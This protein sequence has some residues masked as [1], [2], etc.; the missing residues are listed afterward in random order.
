MVNLVID[1]KIVIKCHQP[2]RTVLANLDVAKSL[3]EFVFG[4][5]EEF[6]KS[7]YLHCLYLPVV[8][9]YRQFHKFIILT[10]MLPFPHAS[11]ISWEE[12]LGVTLGGSRARRF[13]RARRVCPGRVHCR[14]SRMLINGLEL[15]QMCQGVNEISRSLKRARQRKLIKRSPTVQSHRHE[16]PH[17]RPVGM[18]RSVR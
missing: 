14:C 16:C 2:Q 17:S 5:S 18:R 1:D 8:A 3:F 13:T 11:A 12:V 7:R 6:C 9:E 10:M 15:C 4:R